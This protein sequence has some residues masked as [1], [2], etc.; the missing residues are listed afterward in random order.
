M[1]LDYFYSLCTP[2]KIYFIIAI[3]GIIN[4]VKNV[5]MGYFG[6]IIYLSIQI[7]FIFI[8]TYFLQ[9]LCRK[10]YTK[11]SW[12]LVFFP[13]ILLF[14]FLFI[15]ILLIVF[16]PKK[17]KEKDKEIIEQI[18]HPGKGEPSTSSLGGPVRKRSKV[19]LDISDV[20]IDI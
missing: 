3:I 17:N 6:L 12:I 11:L 5:S 8:W 1:N 20:I 15:I 16:F 13:L 10:G 2:A 18:R 4:N 14:L 7:F 9:L 19:G